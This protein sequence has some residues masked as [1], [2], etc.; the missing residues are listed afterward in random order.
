MKSVFFLLFIALFFASCKKDR[1]CS[2]K[3][4]DGSTASQAT[5][6]NVTKKEA[7]NLCTSS[8]A[9]ITCSVE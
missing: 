2:C 4:A 6:T 1:V 8:S 9:G 3:Y 7:T 5:Y